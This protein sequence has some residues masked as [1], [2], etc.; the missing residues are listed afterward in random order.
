MNNSDTA[1][2]RLLLEGYVPHSAEE[3]A[4]RDFLLGWLKL[5][6]ENCLSRDNISSHFPST[7]SV[8]N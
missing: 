3:A 4:D 7:G 1:A 5:F 2:L 6:P 8:M